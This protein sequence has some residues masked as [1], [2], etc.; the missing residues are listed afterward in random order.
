LKLLPY[1]H[2]WRQKSSS[3]SSSS[4]RFKSQCCEPPYPSPRTARWA[5][6]VHHSDQAA[7]AVVTEP[8]PHKALK[9]CPSPAPRWG[10]SCRWPPASQQQCTRPAAAAAG[11]GL[12]RCRINSGYQ[13]NCTQQPNDC[14]AH[15]LRSLCTP[16]AL[17]RI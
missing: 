7:D 2:T 9:N 10:S 16:C 12:S 15:S 5:P 1:T 11:S 13:A 8:G 17:R 6:I 3:N 4:N 14:T